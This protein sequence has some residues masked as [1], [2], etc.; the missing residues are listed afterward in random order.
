MLAGRFIVFDVDWLLDASGVLAGGATVTEIPWAG[1]DQAWLAVA[2]GVAQ[3]GLATVLLGTVT[4]D[5][6]EPNVGREWV[7]AVHSLVLDCADE[8]RRQRTDARPE[9]RLQDTTQQ[10]SFG[11]WL[12]ETIADRVDTSQCSPLIANCRTGRCRTWRCPCFIAAQSVMVAPH[13]RESPRPV[14]RASPTKSWRKSGDTITGTYPWK[15]CTTRLGAQFLGYVAGDDAV[16]AVEQ[17]DQTLVTL[18]IMLAA[19]GNSI[20]GS[21]EVAFGTCAGADG[22]FDATWALT[23]NPTT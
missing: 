18:S 19:P 12:R 21:W 7:G 15:G 1:F 9:W 3:S 6:V 20:S 10:I 22:P 14:G 8:V 4:P 2:H 23:P 17:A 16:V 5:R 11:Q 13:R